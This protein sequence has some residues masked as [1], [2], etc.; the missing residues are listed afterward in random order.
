MEMQDKA[1][2]EAYISLIENSL[3]PAEVINLKHRSCGVCGQNVWTK[4]G[5]GH[6]LPHVLVL[7]DTI[8]MVMI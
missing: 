4:C 5:V 2:M 1:E 3:L 7:S 6:G 8:I